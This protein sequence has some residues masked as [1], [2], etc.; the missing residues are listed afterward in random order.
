MHL[1]HDAVKELNDTNELNEPMPKQN[2]K[3]KQEKRQEQFIHLI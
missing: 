3:Y 1:L 2:H